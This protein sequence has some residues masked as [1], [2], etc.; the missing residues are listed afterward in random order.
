MHS[1]F[2][3]GVREHG[4]L[5]AV[6]LH[7]LANH[8]GYEAELLLGFN[9]FVFIVGLW[10]RVKSLLATVC[11]A[12]AKI[13]DVYHGLVLGKLGILVCSRQNA[14]CN[15]RKAEHTN[16]RTVDNLHFTG[17]IAE[18]NFVF[19]YNFLSVFKSAEDIVPSKKE[20]IRCYWI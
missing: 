17:L 20:I 1:P 11:V 8:G 19:H 13:W 5:K 15:C 10:G 14:H 7:D 12:V 6:T 2:L 4:N 16:D 3:K 9:L 18:F